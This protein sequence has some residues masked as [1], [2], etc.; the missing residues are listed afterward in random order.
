MEK[1]KTILVCPLD[2]GLGH[3]TRLVPVI[4]LL[5]NKG[6]RVIIGADNR[7]L[8]YLEQRFPNC[9]FIRFPGFQPMYPKSGSMAIAMAKAYPKMQASAKKS[10]QLLQDFINEHDIDI[11]ISDNRYELYSELAYTVFITHQLNIKAPGLT[12]LVKPLIKSKINNYIKKHDELWIPDFESEPN[13][14]ADLSHVKKFPIK[15][16]HFIGPLSRFT[17]LTTDTYSKKID[18]LIILSGPEPQRTMLENLL[19]EQALDTNYTTFVL[20]GKPEFSAIKKIKNVQVI[21]HASDEKIA[22]WMHQAKHIVC[23][24]GYSTIMDLAILGKKA[25]FIPTPG[26]TEQIYLA[27]KFKAQKYFNSTDQ[28]EIQLSKHLKEMGEYNGFRIN[29][30]SDSL[31][32][33]I[34][35][36][37]STNQNQLY[38]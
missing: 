20:Q 10:H 12:K 2:W 9:E 32:Q 4:D 26:Q 23:R 16:Y 34:N 17:L 38:K 13:L 14:S 15:N 11:V 22:D 33:R 7:P 19:I 27:K 21:P 36:L 37:L 18:L 6:S 5:V 31:K 24:P 25:I 3:A 30:Q 28:N 1:N 35:T 8:A 29:F